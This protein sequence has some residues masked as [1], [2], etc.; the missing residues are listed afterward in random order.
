MVVEPCAHS[1]SS[2]DDHAMTRIASAAHSFLL[3]SH[4]FRWVKEHNEKKGV[5]PM[6]QTTLRKYESLKSE[7]FTKAKSCNLPKRTAGIYK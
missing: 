4:T 1:S 2:G 7:T 3:G 6:M 5:A